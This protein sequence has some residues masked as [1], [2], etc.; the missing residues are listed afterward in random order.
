V[1]RLRSVIGVRRV[2]SEYFVVV[3]VVSSVLG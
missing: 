2:G 1:R 3:S